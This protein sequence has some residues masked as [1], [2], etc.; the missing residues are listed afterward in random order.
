MSTLHVGIGEYIISSNPEDVLKT[1][2][3][4]SCVA[5]MVYDKVE[6]MGA[7]IHI[8]LPD[9]SIDPEKA[10]DRPAY[11]VDTG[12]AKMFNEI[13]AKGTSRRNVWIKIAGGASIMDAQKT[14]DIGRRNALAIK[15][16]LWKHRF[17]VLK[18]DIGGTGS[19]TVTFRI[20]DGD[21]ILSSGNKELCHL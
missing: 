7:L 8:A 20:E 18:E 9:S 1:Y 13:S 10:A 15:K 14:F 2:G 21:I 4:G 11:F 3:L 19:R 17:G 12:M 6:K 5:V 16:W